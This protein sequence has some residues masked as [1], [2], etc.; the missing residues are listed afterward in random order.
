M[1]KFDQITR[2][3]CGYDLRGTP[4][5]DGTRTCPECGARAPL[6]GPR[7]HARINWV[8]PILTGL[9]LVAGLAVLGNRPW[10]HYRNSTYR[11]AVLALAVPAAGLLTG[12]LAALAAWR[13]GRTAKQAL[14]IGLMVLVLTIVLGGNAV[15]AGEDKTKPSSDTLL[16]F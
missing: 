6:F 15:I 1:G 16:G 12:A 3:S 4:F 10:D 8:A 11:L 7:P 14:L 9:I 2:C 13:A 5:S